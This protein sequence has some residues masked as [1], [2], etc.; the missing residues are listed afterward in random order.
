M[1]DI[2]MDELPRWMA[3]EQ[4]AP[5]DEADALFAAVASRYLPAADAPASLS[6]HIMAALPRQ[7]ASPWARAAGDL[8]A[9]WW[10]RAT[11]VAAFVVLGMSL[12]TV[13]TSQVFDL[14]AA[15]VEAVA[16][17]AHGLSTSL[18]AASRLAKTLSERAPSRLAAHWPSRR[19]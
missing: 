5:W 14:T 10:V 18:S 16:R 4:D 6:A 2:D 15:S 12:S 3:A 9:S 19:R 8:V 13:S 11:L 7:A 17:T 1:S